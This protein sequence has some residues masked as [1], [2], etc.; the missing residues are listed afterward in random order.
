M[1]AGVC[2]YARDAQKEMRVF[3]TGKQGGQKNVVFKNGKNCP[4]AGACSNKQDIDS[5]HS[6]VYV[7]GAG[8]GVRVLYI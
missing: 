6:R 4:H 1:Y 7:T 2:A 5:I 8:A 3:K